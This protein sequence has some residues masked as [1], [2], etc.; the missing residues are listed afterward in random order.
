MVL[1]AVAY[2]TFTSNE[3]M[4]RRMTSILEGNTSGREALYGA[5]VTKWYNSNNIWNLLFGFGFA[6]SLE[7]TGGNFAHND[8][9]ELLSNFGLAG[10]FAYLLLFYAAVK[11]LLN[12]EWMKDERYLLLTITI[13]VVLYYI[14]FNVVYFLRRV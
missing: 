4:M 13:I 7:I 11:N 3:F 9:L 12:T 14:G 8:W 10:I 6:S 2:K 5:I 1:A